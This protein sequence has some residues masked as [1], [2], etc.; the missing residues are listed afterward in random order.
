MRFIKE[1]HK[2]IRRLPTSTR[3][4]GHVLVNLESNLHIRVHR[5]ISRPEFPRWPLKHQ[6]GLSTKRDGDTAAPL[7]AWWRFEALFHLAPLPSSVG[8]PPST[9][10]PH[11]QES[12]KDA[13]V[14]R[15]VVGGQ[16]QWKGTPAYADPGIVGGR[17]KHPVTEPEQPEVH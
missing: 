7:D 4:D 11:R 10:R 15:V 6:Q 3:V 16:R 13:V 12:H 17:C 5:C 8:K 9:V 2:G 1:E 14:G